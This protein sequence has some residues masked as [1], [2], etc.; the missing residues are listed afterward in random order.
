[1]VRRFSPRRL[2]LRSSIQSANQSHASVALSPRLSLSLSL[3]SAF[4]FGFAIR[5][6]G[7]VLELTIHAR[8][9]SLYSIINRDLEILKNLKV[10]ESAIPLLVY[11]ADSCKPAYYSRQKS[12]RQ[13]FCH[14]HFC[15]TRV[16]TDSSTCRLIVVCVY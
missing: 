6:A 10:V 16:L 5:P 12:C 1:M 4:G 8:Q 7:L 14:Q 15:L 3:S 2:H 9:K 11:I 13:T